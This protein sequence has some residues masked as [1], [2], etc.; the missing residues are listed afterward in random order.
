MSEF[1]KDG[2]WG[3]FP[4]LGIGLLLL[5]ASVLYAVRPSAKRARVGLVLGLVTLASG[6]LGASVGLATSARF[7]PK[8]AKADQLEILAQGFAESIH[9][10]V[11]ALI[12][13][14]LAGLVASVGAARSADEPSPRGA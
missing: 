7:I 2:G 9:N 1:F 13:V 6:M 3:M 11:L 12:V 5:A 8:V 10:V 4:T 14:V